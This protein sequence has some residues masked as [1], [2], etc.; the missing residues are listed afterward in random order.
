[1]PSPKNQRSAAAGWGPLRG[2]QPVGSGG[3]VAV[4][5][6]PWA[7]SPSVTGAWLPAGRRGVAAGAAAA[8][9]AAT[10]TGA[11]APALGGTAPTVGTALTAAEPER[12]TY[13]VAVE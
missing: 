2:Y 13:A 8:T 6:R 4:T 10:A 9:P 12:V 5:G 11:P 3:T 1:M 7:V